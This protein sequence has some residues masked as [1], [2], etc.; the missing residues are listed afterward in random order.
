MTLE[1]VALERVRAVAMESELIVVQIFYITAR[2]C[3]IFCM[4]DVSVLEGVEG[5]PR[6]P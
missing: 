5:Q 3:V 2:D 4:A 1:E 6:P